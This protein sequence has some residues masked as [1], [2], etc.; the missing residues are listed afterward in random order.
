VERVEVSMYSVVTIDDKD[1]VVTTIDVGEHNRIMQ[2]DRK[3]LREGPGHRSG[4]TDSS[5]SLPWVVN[6][7]G[8]CP[9]FLV[10]GGSEC[11]LLYAGAGI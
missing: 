6:K 10:V 7:G 4:G 9:L 8:R 11:V 1:Y 2:P 3:P 5:Y